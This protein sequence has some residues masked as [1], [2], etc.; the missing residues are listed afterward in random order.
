MENRS[1]NPNMPTR[2]ERLNGQLQWMRDVS[3]YFSINRSHARIYDAA[4][5]NIAMQRMSFYQ[6]SAAHVEMNHLAHIVSPEPFVAGETSMTVEQFNLGAMFGSMIARKVWEQP[7]MRIVGRE[8][9][10]FVKQYIA[11]EE[12]DPNYDLRSEVAVAVASRAEIGLDQ[13]RAYHELLEYVHKSADRQGLEREF[14]D[15]GFGFA[16]FMT[17]SAMKRTDAED[18]EQ[19][20]ALVDKTEDIDWDWVRDVMRTQDPSDKH[21]YRPLDD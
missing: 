14:F 7:A 5:A 10:D 13:A 20:E 15:R 8:V 4:A 2:V 16:I 1:S 11:E 19:F 18:M 3:P 9:L 12:A 21:M 6:G 17:L